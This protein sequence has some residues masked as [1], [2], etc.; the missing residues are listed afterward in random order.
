MA[1][2]R[3]LAVVLLVIFMA[4][5]YGAWFT[6]DDLLPPILRRNPVWPSSFPKLLAITGILIS[7]V[8]IL[9]LEKSGIK[10][11]GDNLDY[12]KWRVYKT[13]HA[14]GLI[15]LMTA[16]AF[17]LRPIG[18][19]AATFLFLTLSSLLLGERRYVLLATVGIAAAGII[20]YLVD[21]VLGIYLSPW[22]AFFA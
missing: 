10:H 1:L 8:V 16:Y 7:V 6:M 20:W 3:W 11:D 5:G 21:A 18:F 15:V 2:D 12:R 4:Y 19:L 22:P 17:M 9:N 14:I 13:G